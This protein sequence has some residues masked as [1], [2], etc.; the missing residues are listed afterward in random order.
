MHTLIAFLH[1]ATTPHVHP[2]EPQT[3]LWFTVAAGLSAAIAAFFV[4]RQRTRA[5]LERATLSNGD[6]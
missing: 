4:M 6:A 3:M 2:E 1:P 5:R